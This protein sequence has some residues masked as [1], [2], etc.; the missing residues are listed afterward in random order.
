V[1]TNDRFSDAAP[2]P[3]QEASRRTRRDQIIAAAAALF[4]E[5]GYAGASMRDI[6]ER[7]GMLKGSLYVH[8]SSKEEMLLEIVST[9]FR[10]FMDALQPILDEAA[11]AELQCRLAIEAH[12]SVVAADPDSAYV[13]VHEARH[14]QGQPLLWVTDAHRRYRAMWNQIFGTGVKRGEFRADLDVEAVTLMA[15]SACDRYE[16]EL[17]AP[18]CGPD[19]LAERVSR[20][21]LSGCLIRPSTE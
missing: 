7:V 1:Q 4:R 11:S 5:K 16:P 10:R 21:L 14:L 17:L 20:V 13:F 12:L 3:E 2:W 19:A 8:V 9:A 6:G 15:L 18:V